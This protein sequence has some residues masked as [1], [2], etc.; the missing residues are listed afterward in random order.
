MA[1]VRDFIDIID[2]AHHGIPEIP[3]FGRYRFARARGNL[4]T[5]IHAGAFEIC[6]LMEGRQVFRVAGRSWLIHAGDV[7]CTRPDERHDSAD[8]P[9]EIAALRWLQI[10]PPKR[11]HG[12]L[13]LDAAASADLVARLRTLPRVFRAPAGVEERFRAGFA[14]IAANDQLA[15]AVGI[16]DLLIATCANAALVAG[17]DDAALHDVVR[18]VDANLD[19]AIPVAE[20]A[21]AA[22]LTVPWFTARFTRAF[23]QSPARYVMRRRI[24]RALELLA[25]G[26]PVTRVALDLGFASSQ[27][28]AAVVKQWTGKS[29]RAWMP[30]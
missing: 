10:V 5:H 4:E 14:A 2:L 16:A 11:G 8:R 12:F 24:D 18:H 9:M 26:R 29:P 27:H 13:R 3:T 30:D 17:D 28:F 7:F 19:R 15:L 25:G 6:Y 22:G 23:G 21:H 1:T 20:L